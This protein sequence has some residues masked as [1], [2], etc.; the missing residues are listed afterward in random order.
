[1]HVR[2]FSEFTNLRTGEHCEDP[3]A[4]F[5]TILTEPTNFGQNERNGLT[6]A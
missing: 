1:M 5:A 3:N 6:D 2:F 4:M